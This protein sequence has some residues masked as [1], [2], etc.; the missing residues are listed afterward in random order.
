MKILIFGVGGM[1][2]HMIYEYFQRHAVHD[3]FGTVLHTYPQFASPV[4]NHII[5]LDV[6]DTQRVQT[7]IAV[8]RPDVVIN[9]V[10]ILPAVANRE[11]ATAI[12]VNALFP[13]ELVE[14]CNEYDCRL[15]H[16]STDCVF[17]GATGMYAER[18]LPNAYTVYGRTKALGEIM[19][20]PHLTIRTSIVG[21]E[22]KNEGT[23]LLA[24]FLRQ[25]GTV[26]GFCNAFWNGVTTLQ[27]AKT[28]NW[29]LTR[30]I[31]GLVH[32]TGPHPISKYDLLC[33][34]Q[35]TW[36]Q[37]DREIVA[38]EEPRI[39]RTL[40]NTR[41]DFRPDVPSYAEMIDDLAHW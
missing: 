26:S 1:A 19:A 9:A 3:T 24:W 7:L 5:R 16:I 8:I 21:P 18:D 38:V 22:Q 34:F 28:I 11:V 15:I 4:T 14:I 20:G 10:G 13:H 30:P 33:M 29:A 2:G 39:N 17:D 25:Q 36:Y 23:G 6:R 41:A 32:L 35:K 27:L 40:R 31:S 37:A 12:R